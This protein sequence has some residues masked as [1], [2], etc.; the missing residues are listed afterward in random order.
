MDQ[1]GYT[2]I[3]AGNRELCGDEAELKDEIDVSA[4]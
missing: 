3:M 2:T 4:P 1:D